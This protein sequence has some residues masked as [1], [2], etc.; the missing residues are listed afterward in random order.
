MSLNDRIRARTSYNFLLCFLTAAFMLLIAAQLFGQL[1]TGK[2]SGTVRDTSGAVIP[3][4][5]V[6]VKSAATGAERSVQSGGIGQYLIPALTPGIYEVRVTNK[7]FKTFRTSV[8]VTVG[9]SATL[10]AQLEIGESTT[11]VEVVGGGATE[12]NTQTQE[13]SQLVDRQQMAQLPSLTR[14]AYDFVALSGNVSNGDSTSVNQGN[15]NVSGSGQSLTTRGV[16]FSLNGQR[17]TGTE[18]LLDGV[19]NVAV[20]SYAVGENVPIDSVQ[21]YSVITNNFSA[22]YGRASGGVVNVTTKAGTNQ[23]H[24]SGWEFNRLAAYTAN[25]YANVV[26]GL[27]KGQYTRNQFGYLIGGPILKNKLFISQSTEWTRVRSQASLSQEILDPSFLAML[28]ANT[29]AYFGKFGTGGYPVSGVASTAGP[30]GI[31]GSQINGTG[32][33]ISATQAVFD[34]VN[35]KANFDAGGGLPGNQYDLVGRVDYNLSD[36]TQ[37]FFRAGRE[38]IVY[39]P[40]TVFYSPYPQYDVGF[41]DLNQSYLYSLTHAFNSSLLNNS[42][43]SFT[44]FNIQN[45]FDKALV[46]TPSLELATPADP[47]TGGY[48]QMPGLQNQGPGAGGL[49]YGGPQNT[50]QVADDLSWSKGRHNLK[51]GGMFTY[52]QLNIA[53]GA[54]AQAEELL[55]PTFATSLND[56][57][58]SAGTPGG[59]QLTNFS[60]RVNPQGALPCPVDQFGNLLTNSSCAVT[61]PLNPAANARSYRFKDWAIYSQDSFRLT[62]RLTLN[63]GLR[64]EHYGVQHNNNQSLDSNFYYGSGSGIEQQVQNGQVQLTQKSSSGQFWAPRWGTAA[65]RVGFAYDLFG[66]GQSSLRGGFGISYERNFGN[67]TYNA[68]FN[69]P[70][71]A[72]VSATCAPG[73]VGCTTLVT[74]SNLGPLGLPGPASFLPP[75]ELRMP[76]PRIN[77]AQ[78]QFWSLALQQQVAANSIVELSYSGAHGVHLYDLNN[79][80][81]VGGGQAYLG[82]PLITGDACSGSGYVSFDNPANPTPACLTRANQQYA[83]INMRGSRGVSSYSA[84]NF[85]FQTRDL[86]HTGLSLVANYTWA[87]T[88]DDLSSTFDDSLQGL[89]S[90]AGRQSSAHRFLQPEA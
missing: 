26:E 49:P 17:Q 82:E 30:L 9:G 74:N 65:P 85:K 51:F 29:Q 81:Q 73:D 25:T 88:L 54:Y 23:F 89:S 3:G 90:P 44:R 63:Y 37:M 60:V 18:I 6:T 39:L 47:V 27:P 56:L 22:E 87:H 58:N 36:Q 66:N 75:V 67:V 35:Y 43:L 31:A 78:A 84:L 24:G 62:P 28:P 45:S 16:S 40:G 1:E 50:L 68:S 32:A 46:N 76:D 70:A 13:M 64:Y 86:H 14:N 79:I 7:G 52:M 21:E 42:K 20:Y 11:V 83:A 57:I 71:S 33:P 2:I 34:T 69:P 19:E 59:S 41:A 8:E 15:N 12:V 10:D 55:G 4:A 53:Y 72:V 5:T 48:I 61:P 77:V 38:N 80:N